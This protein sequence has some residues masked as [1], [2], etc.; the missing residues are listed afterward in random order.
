LKKDMNDSEV[1]PLLDD[2]SPP[3]NASEVAQGSG[4]VLTRQLSTRGSKAFPYFAFSPGDDA[5]TKSM[6]SPIEALAP[7]AP[8]GVITVQGQ[9]YRKPVATVKSIPP[10]APYRRKARHRSFYLWYINEF[11]HWWKSSRLLVRLGGLET[12]A[13]EQWHEM[14]LLEPKKRKAMKHAFKY[15]KRMGQGGPMRGFLNGVQPFTRGVR[16]LVAAWRWFESAPCRRLEVGVEES[17]AFMGNRV[18]RMLSRALVDAVAGL[19]LST[20]SGLFRAHILSKDDFWHPASMLTFFGILRAVA[21]FAASFI[22]SRFGRFLSRSFF[23]NAYHR[24]TPV[25]RVQDVNLRSDDCCERDEIDENAYLARLAKKVA[26][27]LG[28]SQSLGVDSMGKQE[29]ALKDEGFHLVGSGSGGYALYE[30]HRT[31]QQDNE[32]AAQT[33]LLHVTPYGPSILNVMPRYTVLEV[34]GSQDRRHVWSKT[35]DSWRFEGPSV[36]EGYC[37]EGAFFSPHHFA[38]LKETYDKQ[39]L[40][41]DKACRNMAEARKG[42]KTGPPTDQPALKSFLQA[43]KMPKKLKKN[44]REFKEL[45]RRVSNVAQRLKALMQNK[46]G[47]ICPRGVIL[48]FEGLDCSGKSST[49]GL[50]QQALEQAGFEVEMRQHNRPPTKEQKSQP[51]MDRFEPPDVSEE[52]SDIERAERGEQA[53]LEVKQASG[54]VGHRHKAMVW[55]RGP[56]GDFVYGDLSAASA[57][58][59]NSRY[60]EFLEFDAECKR[61]NILFCKLMFVTNRDSIASTL[62]KRLAQRKMAQDLRTWLSACRGADVSNEEHMLAGLDQIT[63]HI[64]PTDFIAFNLYQKNLYKFI[65]FA[66]NTDTA[67]NPWIVV[68]TTDRY[69]ARDQL[70]GVF[71]TQVNSFNTRK[72]TSDDIIRWSHSRAGLEET[73]EPQGVEISV[74]LQKELG[75]R[76]LRLRTILALIVTLVLVWYYV[77]NTPFD[78]IFGGED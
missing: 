27:A 37:Y 12:L 34:E 71:Q 7:L 73:A 15:A 6:V 14:E 70:L 1:T 20:L 16:L 10:F 13:R 21:S 69:N 63:L 72:R 61:K 77:E 22:G 57:K 75:G 35:L 50:V 78:W 32:V 41:Y 74:M 44:D 8:M 18:S 62:G 64:D 17:L 19:A 49:G 54:C 23:L 68:N 25:Q 59:K 40:A 39:L 36:L 28:K 48:Y 30:C 51:W 53:A 43:G 4:P 67:A 52:I 58:E 55:D 76:R 9:K 66:L 47:C 3:A 11:R 46:G 65:N 2:Q 26:K 5:L 31:I 33:I 56:A 38:E 45:Q 24:W 60:R 42:N 29:G